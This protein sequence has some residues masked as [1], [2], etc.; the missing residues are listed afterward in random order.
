MGFDASAS[1]YQTVDGSSAGMLAAGAPERRVS[2][3]GKL[4]LI[5]DLRDQL[6]KVRQELK[7]VTALVVVSRSK[8]S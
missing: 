7:E 3:V 5:Q 8:S 1:S 4:T 2:S 6:K